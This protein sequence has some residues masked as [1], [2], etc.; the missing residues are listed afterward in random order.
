[1]KD[2]KL[3]E[4]GIEAML[5][6]YGIESSDEIALSQLTMDGIPLTQP[7]DPFRVL[8]QTPVKT[9]NVLAKQFA[10]VTLSLRTA[11]V[12]RPA[13]GGRFRAEPIFLA[14]SVR[15]SARG[16]GP[17]VDLSTIALRNAESLDTAGIR[18]AFKDLLARGELRKK[19]T[20]E[21]PLVVGVS[22]ENRPRM[23]VFGDTEFI[24][25]DGMRD[26]GPYSL[27]ISSLEWMS[28]H[29]ALIGPQ[30]VARETV[31]MPDKYARDNYTHI[32]L[33]PMWLM[34]VSIIGLGGGVWLV[35]RR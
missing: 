14:R 28:E 17:D 6:K 29:E 4:S 31:E 21:R 19:L 2:R 9:E 12:I 13:Q 33:I 5:K 10:G 20:E 22:D 27:F 35:R 30:P 25:N 16:Q 18:A 24:S 23:V 3:K 15:V 1:V 26:E 32:H 8:A 34:L 11:R 7:I